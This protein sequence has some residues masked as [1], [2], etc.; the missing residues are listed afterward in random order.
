VATRFAHVSLVAEDWKRLA[1]FYEA[2]FGC[3]PVPPVRNLE[4]RWLE[5]ATG[6]RG[7]RLAGIH[8]RL[9]GGGPATIEIFQ[10]ER[11]LPRFESAANRPGWGH[12]AFAVDDVK[13]CAERI[14]A[15]GGATVGEATCAEIPG[16]G[17]LCF[18]YLADPEGNLIEIQCWS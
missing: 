2:V 16:A 8:L 4:G 9:P 17:R 6:V 5:Q 15:H 11:E 13:L 18:Q 12:V 10:Y 1:G 14:A 3:T 7:A